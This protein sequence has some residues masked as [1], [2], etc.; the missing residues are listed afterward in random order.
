MILILK[1]KFFF[2]HHLSHAE[3]FFFFSFDEA[4]V[5]TADGVGEWAT[6]TVATVK[7]QTKIKKKLPTL[8][9]LLYQ[10]LLT[11]SFKVNSGYYKLMGLALMET[12]FI[13]KKFIIC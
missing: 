2:E 11:T 7:E 6:T 9:G 3:C 1:I 8:F 12:L 5:L 4:V 10:Y 13:L